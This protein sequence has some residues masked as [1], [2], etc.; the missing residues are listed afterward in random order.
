MYIY[1]Y[2]CSTD[3]YRFGLKGVKWRFSAVQR[4]LASSLSTG[5]GSVYGLG[6]SC[7]DYTRNPETYT[8]SE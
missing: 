4:I 3:F 2:I 8:M 5:K 6:K 7:T 1:S